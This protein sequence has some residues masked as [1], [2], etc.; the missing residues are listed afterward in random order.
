TLSRQGMPLLRYR[1]GDWGRMRTEPCGCGCLKPRLEEVKGR[2]E[3]GVRL[4]DGSLLSIRQ[5]DELLLASGKIQ[6]F[7]ASYD[8]GR[9]RLTVAVMGGEKGGDAVA[10]AASILET[11]LG[12]RLQI[13]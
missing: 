12:G 1:T 13:Q 9:N 5:L 3:D 4:P 2:L 6:D 10:E 7:S 8:Q 11:A